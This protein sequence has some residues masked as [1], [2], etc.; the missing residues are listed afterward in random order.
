MT[1][2]TRGALQDAVDW[3][4]DGAR[5]MRRPQDV[6]AALGARLLDVGLP[7]HRVALFV[8]TLHPGMIGRRFVWRPGAAVE[9]SEGSY[10]FLTTDI[11]QRSP[12]VVLYETGAPV[13][14]RLEDPACPADFGI[15][16]ELRAEGVTDYL[17]QPLPFSNGEIHGI[18]WTTKRPGGF[19][20][21]DLA[22][23]DAIQRPLARMVEIYALRRTAA[24]LLGTYVG[25]STAARILEGRIRRGD[26]ERIDAVIL[27]ADLRGF[28]RLSDTLPGDRVVGLLNGWFDAL[29]P[30]I[31]AAGGEV[32]KFIGDGLLA[33]FPAAAAPRPPARPRC[34]RPATPKPRWPSATRRCAPAARRRCATA[35]RSIWARS[36]TAI[37]AAP[38]GSTSPRSARRST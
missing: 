3:L 25:H 18:S 37:S 35:W 36:N 19:S 6:M 5:D 1:E 38:P 24:T 26:I 21:A 14:R 4:I 9:I 23:L 30:A 2:R 7:L 12:V 11:Y 32:L 17:L 28:T 33:I 22:A 20:E 34:W 8:R 27:L 29:V 16:E 31:E 15:V 13:R 10:D